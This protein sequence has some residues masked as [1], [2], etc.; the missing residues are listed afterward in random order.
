MVDSTLEVVKE[1]IERDEKAI[2]LFRLSKEFILYK[3]EI[4]N[5][6]KHNG[7]ELLILLL[8]FLSSK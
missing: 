6:K 4:Y 3:I 8:I 7:S 5:K 1:K 2:F